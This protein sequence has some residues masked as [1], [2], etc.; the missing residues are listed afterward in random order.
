MAAAPPNVESQDPPSA[1]RADPRPRI[2]FLFS[3]TGGG[4]RASANAVARAMELEYPG[5]FQV[6]LLDPFVDGSRPFLR[7]L[8]Y[9]YGFLIKH[10]PMLYGAIYHVTDN[11]AVLRA[12]I[13]VLGRQFRPGMRG[14]LARPVAAVVSFHPLLNHVV[15]ETMHQARLSLPFI[16]VVTD[17]SDFHRGWLAPQADLVVV[18][19]PASRRY[20]VAR[21]LDPRRVLSAGLPVDPR[22]TGPLPREEKR[23]LRARL[24]LEEAPTLLLVSGG[25]GSGRLGKQAVALDAAGLG[26]QLLVVCGRNARLRERLQRRA[27]RGRVHVLGFVDNMPELMQAADAVVT[28]AGPGTIAEALVSGLPLFLTSYVPGQEEGNVHFILEQKV[29]WYVPRV[30][31]LV[32]RVRQAFQEDHEELE[33]MQGRADRIGRPQA[34]AEIAQL[35]AATVEPPAAGEW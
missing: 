15:I 12:A 3:D 18:P 6:E 31:R 7:W 20:C 27:W 11:R 29:G 13:K 16:T 2:L 14:N 21:G 28:K 17:M 4:H 22:F 19:S 8:V 24:G 32:E 10:T 33:R 5:R 26:L 25:E 23:R 1:S 34:A 9:R 35:I 30:R